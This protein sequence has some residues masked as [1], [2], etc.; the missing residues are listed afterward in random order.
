[1]QWFKDYI[2][3]PTHKWW[4][5]NVWRPSWTK[6]V[7]FIYGVPALVAALFTQ[8]ASWGEDTTIAQYIDKLHVPNWVPMAFAGIALVHYIAHGRMT[9]ETT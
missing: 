2:A 4:V 1:M 6:V 7:T 3:G 9:N 5:D 8:L